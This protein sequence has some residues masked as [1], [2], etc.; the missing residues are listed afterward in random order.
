MSTNPAPQNRPPDNTDALA[1]ILYRLEHIER[2]MDRLLTAEL[3]TANHESV[4]RRVDALEAAQDE[5]ERSLRQVVAGVITA[6]AGA[7]VIAGMT[8]L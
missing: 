3:Y 1:V 6:V 7:A 5:Q 8:L 4:S 2:R